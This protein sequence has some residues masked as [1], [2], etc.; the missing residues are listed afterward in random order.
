MRFR[1]LDAPDTMPNRVLVCEGEFDALL[2]HRRGEVAV[3]LPGAT[4]SATVLS[5]LVDRLVEAPRVA[6]VTDPGEAGEVSTDRLVR[7]LVDRWGRR[8]ALDRVEVWRGPGDFTET[9]L[10]SAA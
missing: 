9:M 10:G 2:A 3:G 1:A 6:I 5:E 8:W 4:P 7:A